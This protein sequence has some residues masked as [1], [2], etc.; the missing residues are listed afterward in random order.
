[1]VKNI[2]FS[3]GYTYIDG[4]DGFEIDDEFLYKYLTVPI[5]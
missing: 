5:K 2:L 3:N 1:M 4:P